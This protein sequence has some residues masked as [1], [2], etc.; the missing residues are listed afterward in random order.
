M[1]TLAS[2][3]DSGICLPVQA[4]EA[5]A[6]AQQMVEVYAEFATQAAAMPVIMGRK[7]RI[8]SFCG[9]QCHLHHRGHDGRPARIAGI[10]MCDACTPAVMQATSC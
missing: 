1:Q 2:H 7:S 6:M 9:R 5:R 10:N 3:D 8:E 4:E